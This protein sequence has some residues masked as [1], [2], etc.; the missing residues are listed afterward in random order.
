MDWSPLWTGLPY[1]LVLPMDWPSLWTDPPYGPTLPMDRLSLWTDPPHGLLL[2]KGWSFLCSGPS[3]NA[4]HSLHHLQNSWVYPCS[5][6]FPSVCI[7]LSFSFLNRK[8][9]DVADYPPPSKAE[10]GSGMSCDDDLVE[11]IGWTLSWGGAGQMGVWEDLQVQLL[12]LSPPHA[13]L[14]APPLYP[15]LQG[16]LGPLSFW[17]LASSTILNSSLL[18]GFLSLRLTFHHHVSICVLASK[19]CWHLPFIHLSVC[20]V[21][22]SAFTFGEQ[23]LDLPYIIKTP[24]MPTWC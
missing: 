11:P 5:R 7:F 2:P 16:S 24:I 18:C 22:S 4:D 19:T 21:Q 12:L 10:E 15:G 20:H 1:G 13:H 17:N 14:P 6:H 9:L 3:L 23:S 8:Y